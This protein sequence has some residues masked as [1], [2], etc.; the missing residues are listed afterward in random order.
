MP[1]RIHEVSLGT[2]VQGSNV[3]GN[4][5]ETRKEAR[6][7]QSPTSEEAA[8]IGSSTV[9][10]GVVGIAIGSALGTPV[11][12]CAGVVGA[13]IGLLVSGSHLYRAQDGQQHGS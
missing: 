8:S 2:I 10:G 13:L 9:G 6:A 7:L 4:I 12:I 3:A 5:A 11:M 1:K